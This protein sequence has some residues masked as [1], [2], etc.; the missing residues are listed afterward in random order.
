[1]ENTQTNK[2]TYKWAK[3]QT[4]KQAMQQTECLCI[5]LIKG[6]EKKI[7]DLYCCVYKN[8]ENSKILAKY[9]IQHYHVIM[10]LYLLPGFCILYKYIECWKQ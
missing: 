8:V 6:N 5:V 10:D 4:K 2:E 9:F 7:D 1:M 3:A